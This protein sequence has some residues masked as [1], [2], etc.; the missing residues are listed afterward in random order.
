[1]PL[2]VVDLYGKIL[3]RTNC[4]DCGHPTCLAFASM[5]VS[6]KRPIKECPHLEP[7]KADACQKE[8]D[9]QHA[10]GKWTRRDMAADA[11]AWARE[12]AASMAI[13]D[14]PQR[15]GGTLFHEAGGPCLAL[16][17]FN[18]KILIRDGRISSENG[19]AL[20][21]WEQ[22]FIYNH[23]A[24]GGSAE[25]AGKWKGLQEIPNTVSKIKSMVSQV[26]T[27]LQQRFAGRIEELAQA[28]ASIGGVDKTAEIGS[29]DAV[30]FFQ[31]LPRCR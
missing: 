17:Y 27:P 8:L 6:E 24:Q 4:G 11:L 29:A 21:R 1:M 20:T 15:I 19:D 28:A 25:P 3:P 18:G 14:L 5:V 13:A 12:R 9:A 30:Y 7:A 22:V 23:M 2:S 16:P 10:A 31:T 26:E